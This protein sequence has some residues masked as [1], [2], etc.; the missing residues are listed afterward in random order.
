MP[1]LIYVTGV[2]G[3]G[4]SAVRRELRR[5]GHVAVGTDEDGLAS[6]FD[7]ADR[8]VPATRVVDSAAWRSEHTWRIVPSRLDDLVGMVQD[9]RVFV[10]GSAANE[11]EVWD[12]FAA[13]VALIV[14]EATVH[15]R[16]E[17]RTGNN[18]GKSVDERAKV[19]GW[20]QG[21]EENFG[22]YG[23]LIVDA[24]PP[25]GEVATAILAMTS[26]LA[27]AAT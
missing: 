19:I 11:G 23:A 17:S 15:A 8:M 21:Y 3:A 4:K 22:G 25:I 6:F 26:H 20:L 13:V 27:H 16:L 12:R 14:D 9:Q 7:A 18:F 10:C 2:P 1:S 5:L 24:R